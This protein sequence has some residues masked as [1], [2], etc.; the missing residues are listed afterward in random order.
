MKDKVLNLRRWLLKQAAE[1]LR[2]R[3]SAFPRGLLQNFWT[4]SFFLIIEKKPR[5]VLMG[6]CNFVDFEKRSVKIAILK[7]TVVF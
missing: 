6:G 1:H 7:V 4:I 3:I 2:A 5:C